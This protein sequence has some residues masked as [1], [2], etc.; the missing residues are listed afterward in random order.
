MDRLWCFVWQRWLLDAQF[1]NRENYADF[2]D[3]FFNRLRA[4]EDYSVEAVARMD[5]GKGS[6]G[7]F[8]EG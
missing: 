8:A 3:L 4:F 5:A 1:S 2:S 7:S 6:Q